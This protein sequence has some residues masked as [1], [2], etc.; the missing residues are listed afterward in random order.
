MKIK[1]LKVLFVFIKMWVF[2]IYVVLKYYIFLNY[3]VSEGEF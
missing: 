1:F 3:I 2:D